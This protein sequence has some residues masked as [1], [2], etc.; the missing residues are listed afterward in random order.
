M[1]AKTIGELVAKTRRAEG[2]TQADL[3]RRIGTTQS[4][5][6]RLETGRS[7]PTVGTVE[8]ALR[9]CGH[10]LEPRAKA[11]RDSVDESLI[12]AGMRMTPAERLAHH[13]GSRKNLVELARKA[14]PAPARS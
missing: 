11:F 1:R 8:R 7:N 4:A 5:I 3:A 12:A 10:T 13:A 14:R 2:L 6:A 9:A